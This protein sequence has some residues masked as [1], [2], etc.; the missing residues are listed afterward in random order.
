MKS[1]PSFA[2]VIEFNIAVLDQGLRLARHYVE[3]ES[4]FPATVGPHLRHIIEHY[5]ALLDREPGALVD[6]D[7][8]ARDRGV[9]RSPTL[10]IERLRGA[11]QKLRALAGH[12]P[13]EAVSVGF[14]IGIDGA[15]FHL[16]P[17][18]LVREL[19]F[20]ASHAIHHYALIRPIAIAAG[21]ALPDE[22]G[23]APETVR[24]EKL[25]WTT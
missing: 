8:R 6:Y 10:A 17:S 13:D 11:T 9:E 2:D 25:Q 3:C 7:H 5:E 18:S 12:R 4:A 24:Y 19:N 20:V 22:F 14:S 23:K 15:E 1:R 21:V 16:S